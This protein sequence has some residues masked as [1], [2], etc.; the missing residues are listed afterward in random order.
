M[1]LLELDKARVA[2]APRSRARGRGSRGSRGRHGRQAVEA[3]LAGL[4]YQAAVIKITSRAK[5]LSRTKIAIEYLRHDCDHVENELGERRT[6]DEAKADV[7]RWRTPR[8]RGANTSIQMVISFKR[9]T[10]E[11]AAEET[12]QQFASEVFDENQYVLAW[13]HPKDGHPHAHLV[14]CAPGEE[15]A[16]RIRT[17][18][19]QA[20]REKLAELAREHGIRM[21]A[22]C[23]ERHPAERHLRNDTDRAARRKGGPAQARTTRAAR[24]ARAIRTKETREVLN[25]ICRE[26]ER[27]AVREA[28]RFSTQQ[29]RP[30]TAPIFIWPRGDCASSSAR[31]TSAP[32]QHSASHRTVSATRSKPAS[33]R[34]FSTKFT[35]A[36]LPPPAR[37]WPRWPRKRPKNINP[38]PRWNDDIYLRR[39]VRILQP[40]PPTATSP[41]NLVP[42]PGATGAR[43]FGNE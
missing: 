34:A 2:P 3:S 41:L 6:I 24:I 30:V 29:R 42:P 28:V 43:D 8:H 27:R 37:S 7:E 4:G 20:M 26:R 25:R 1:S 40:R 23:Y 31:S 13:H 9:G 14:I 11:W 12:V 5:T 39:I 35:D 38:N 32:H 22:R 19:L 36:Q 15:R 33:A 17:A 21:Q 10:D 18:E 16:L